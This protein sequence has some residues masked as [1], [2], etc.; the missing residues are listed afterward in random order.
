MLIVGLGNPGREFYLTRHNIGFEVVDALVQRT[1]I[2]LKNKRKYLSLI[3]TGKIGEREVILAKPQTYMNQSGVALRLLVEE[4][5]VGL[6][7]LIVIYD[8]LDLPLGQLRIRK[9][10]S[11]GSHK[12]VISTIE[13]LKGSEFIHF[14]IGIGSPEDGNKRTEYVL[15]K[16]KEDER[17]AVEKAIE[18]ATYAVG[19]IVVSGVAV[20]M[21]RFNIKSQDYIGLTQKIKSCERSVKLMAF[22]GM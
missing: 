9:S 6:N 15:S 22:F 11:G 18:W 2:K 16:F 7:D 10:G 17:E 14:R 20:A 5:R 8:D 19:E 4:F 1:K 21:N 12:G 13:A 3:G